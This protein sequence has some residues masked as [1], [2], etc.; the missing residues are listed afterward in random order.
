[1]GKLPL[2]LDS[3]NLL[4]G[5]SIVEAGGV[6]QVFWS[7]AGF[8]LSLLTTLLYK[9]N[10]WDNQMQVFVLI[11]LLI[12]TDTVKPYWDI[13]TLKNIWYVEMGKL[14]CGAFKHVSGS[15]PTFEF[16]YDGDTGQV[17]HVSSPELCYL[18]NKE[19]EQ[20]F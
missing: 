18:W 9:Q 5:I 15:L 7:A 11:L 13:Q 8:S 12:H 3:E 19:G 4:W 2:L 10:H 6:P 20:H 14:E 1:M 16:I 17:T